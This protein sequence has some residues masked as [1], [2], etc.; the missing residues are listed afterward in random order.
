MTDH[1]KRIRE[2]LEAGPTEGP[3]LHNKQGYPKS[4]VRA[5]GDGGRN[6]ANT[7][8]TAASQAKTPEAYKARTDQDRLNAA[9][10]AACNPAAIRALLADLDEARAALTAAKAGGWLPIESAPKDGTVV[11]LGRAGDDDD[12][13][14]VVTTGHWQEA[15]EDGVDY[16]GADAGFVDEHYQEFKPGRSFGSPSYRYAPTQP[17]HW[18][19]FPNPPKEQA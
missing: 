16:M 12:I 17:T 7:W 8:G 18:Q 9:Y 13:A 11:I 2:A 6:I 10:I 4:D 19:P 1:E 3:W 14:S 15:E 5:A